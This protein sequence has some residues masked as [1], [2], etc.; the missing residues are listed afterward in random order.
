MQHG[1][2]VH[3]PQGV[4]MW[5]ETGKGMRMRMTEKP[6]A[7]VYLSTYSQYVYRIYTANAEW[8]IKRRDVYPIGGNYGVS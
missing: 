3:I 7:G 4:E 8:S 1:D 5:D 6:M 2:L